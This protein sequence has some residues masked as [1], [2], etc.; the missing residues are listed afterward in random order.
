MPETPVFGQFLGPSGVFFKSC[1]VA[2]AEKLFFMGLLIWKSGT[3]SN[4]RD[5]VDFHEICPYPTK[6]R[7]LKAKVSRKPNEN[8]FREER[9][10]DDN[11]NNNNDDDDDNISQRGLVVVRCV[12]AGRSRVRGQVVAGL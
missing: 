6:S 2:I 8:L 3:Y 7:W 1:R 9:K 10:D 11:Y 12:V 4:P 5:E